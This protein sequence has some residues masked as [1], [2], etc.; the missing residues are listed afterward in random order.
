VL[1]EID[2]LNKMCSTDSFVS[3]LWKLLVVKLLQAFF[4][5]IKI[6]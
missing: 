4:C 2:F 6:I 3:P 5:M 1:R